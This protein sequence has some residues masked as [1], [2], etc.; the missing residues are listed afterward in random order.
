MKKSFVL[1]MIVGF[2]LWFMLMRTLCQSA[3]DLNMETASRRGELAYQK[4]LLLKQDAFFAQYQAVRQEVSKTKGSDERLTQL[5][6]EIE[7]TAKDETVVI[8]DIRPLPP[9]EQGKISLLRISLQSLERP[10]ATA[11]LP[12]VQ[13]QQRLSIKTQLKFLIN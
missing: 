2:I 10:R 8:E 6:S 5:V 11:R 7:Q 4:G 13:R 9:E 12:P 1:A 3:I